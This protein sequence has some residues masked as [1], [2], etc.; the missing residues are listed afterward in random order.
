MLLM[1]TMHKHK[2]ILP[3][4]DALVM[5]AFG[6]TEASQDYNRNGILIG[7]F[8]LLEKNVPTFSICNSDI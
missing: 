2:G 4:F 1:M 8:N 3:V 5:S 6:S 7:K